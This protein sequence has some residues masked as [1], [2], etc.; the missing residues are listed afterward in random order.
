MMMKELRSILKGGW[1][2]KPRSGIVE[3]QFRQFLCGLFSGEGRTAG[4][5]QAVNIDHGQAGG[6]EDSID[7]DQESL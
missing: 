1:S 2:W 3:K 5:N 7:A 4:H 6:E